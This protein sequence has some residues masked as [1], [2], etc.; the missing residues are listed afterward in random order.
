MPGIA[1]A[2]EAALADRFIRAFNGA[3]TGGPLWASNTPAF[4]W[5]GSVGGFVKVPVRRLAS[6]VQLGQAPVKRTSPVIHLGP[7]RPM[8]DFAQ[9]FS[10]RRSGVDDIWIL[11]WD[12]SGSH[13][14]EMIRV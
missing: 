14:V 2:E 4:V 6:N 12:P 8:G 3:D 7:S 5:S 10:V 9:V 11:R 13:V 1:D